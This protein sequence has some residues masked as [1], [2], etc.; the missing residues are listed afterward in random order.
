MAYLVQAATLT[1]IADQ[2]RRLTG[3]NAPLSPSQMATALSTA[4]LSTN[5]DG[6]VFKFYTES[7]YSTN[8]DQSNYI[9]SAQRSNL[10]EI[11]MPYKTSISDDEFDNVYG[12]YDHLQTAYFPA[13]MSVGVNA[14]WAASALETLTLNSACVISEGAFRNV[15]DPDDKVFRLYLRGT[16]MGS[17]DYSAFTTRI[18]PADSSDFV[19]ISAMDTN[20]MPGLEIYVP[21]SLLNDFKTTWAGGYLANNIYPLTD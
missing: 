9:N 21:A 11:K 2:V 16:S 14:F 15:I 3:T 1:A 5:N 12:G 7:S 4:S 20:P 13:C 8:N 18:Y 10:L 17:C 19:D 6:N